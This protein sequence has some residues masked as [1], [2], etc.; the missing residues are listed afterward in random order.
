MSLTYVVIDASNLMYRARYAAGN[1]RDASAE[2]I[3]GLSLDISLRGIC[4]AFDTFKADHSVVCFDHFSWRRTVLSDYKEERRKD[5]KPAEKEIRESVA[6]VIEEFKKFLDQKTNVTVLCREMVEADDFISYWTQ[7]HPLDK[8]VIISSDSDYKQ[9]I[10]ADRVWLYDPVKDILYDQ[11]RGILKRKRTGE[12]DLFR[13]SWTFEEKIELPEWY[14]FKKILLGKPGELPR[15]APRG[16]GEKKAKTLFESMRKNGIEWNNYMS[17][18]EKDEGLFSRWIENA[19]LSDLLNPPEEIENKM[20]D[21]VEQVCNRT[22]VP[23]VG[24]ELLKFCKVHRLKRLS[25]QVEHISKA[26]SSPYH[27]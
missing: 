9:L 3:A 10:E 8:H 4:S 5:V 16:I 27:K 24:L 26:L 13:D 6:E 14:L 12:Y 20:A 18:I 23:K 21:E 25:E 22:R 7:I 2:D 17:G 19:E 11:E 1:T 15:S